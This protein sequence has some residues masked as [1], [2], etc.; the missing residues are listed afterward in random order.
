MPLDTKLMNG[1]DKRGMRQVF[2]LLPKK[3]YQQ[4]IGRKIQMQWI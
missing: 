2:N 4:H 3:A 1:N